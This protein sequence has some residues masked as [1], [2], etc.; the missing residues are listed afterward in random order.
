MTYP[1]DPND[2]ND[3]NETP[4]SERRS[5][6][7][8][9]RTGHGVYDDEPFPTE[10]NAFHWYRLAVYWKREAHRNGQQQTMSFDETL[11]INGV[12]LS[13][14]DLK[15]IKNYIELGELINAIRYVRTYTGSSLVGG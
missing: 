1:T 3:P 7:S 12:R 15:T 8:H 13:G 6:S 4:I 14:G 9:T 2:P 10:G 11:I 5:I